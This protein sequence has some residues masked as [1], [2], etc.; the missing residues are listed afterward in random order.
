MRQIPALEQI[1]RRVVAAPASATSEERPADPVGWRSGDYA[2]ERSATRD[3]ATVMRELAIRAWVAGFDHRVVLTIRRMVSLLATGVQRGVTLRLEELA[4]EVHL[5]VIRT[6]RW[7][8]ET[9]ADCARARQL[10]L[11]IAPEFSGVGRTAAACDDEAAW[12]AVL[13]LV[14][15]VGWSPRGAESETAAEAY[16]HLLAGCSGSADD[17]ARGRPWEVVSWGWQPK[18][19]ASTLPAP[20][21]EH[22]LYRLQFSATLEQSPRL[23]LLAILALWRDAAASRTPASIEG[24][25]AALDEHVIGPGPALFAPDELWTRSLGGP[26]GHRDSVCR[27]YTWRTFDVASAARR[28]TDNPDAVDPAGVV[29]PTVE[30][31]DADLG[32]MVAEIGA[33]ALVDERHYWGVER[34]H[35]SL[36][37]IEEVDASRASCVTASYALGRAPVPTISPRCSFRTRSVTS[38]CPSCFGAIAVAGDLIEC[39]VCEGNSVRPEVWGL[40]SAAHWMTALLSSDPGRGPVGGGAPHGAEWHV[41]CSDLLRFLVEKATELREEEDGEDDGN[42]DEQGG[43]T[44]GDDSARRVR[45]PACQAAAARER[46]QVGSVSRGPS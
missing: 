27:S 34:R 35:E 23:A 30:T 19:S 41:A 14:D 26:T 17:T 16:L 29:L 36:V 39:S 4:H 32:G 1:L 38:W 40:Q 22:L 12:E 21:R 31:P 2:L 3:A 45:P 9:V 46:L 43:D 28:W 25:A 10:A 37:M 13:D 18:S 20:V 11:G 15:A 5:A 42:D 24:F 7:S 33:A 8:D 6:G 44:G